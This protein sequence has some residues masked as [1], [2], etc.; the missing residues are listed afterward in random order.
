[1]IKYLKERS[2][3]EKDQAFFARLPFTAPHWP[4]QAPPEVV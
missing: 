1:M 3:E 4:L 2:K